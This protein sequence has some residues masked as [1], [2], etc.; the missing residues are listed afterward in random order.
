MD[1]SPIKGLLDVLPAYMNFVTGVLSLTARRPRALMRPRAVFIH[2]LTS[3]T[4]PAWASRLSGVR[5]DP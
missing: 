2:D 3:F 4:P 5:H 1:E